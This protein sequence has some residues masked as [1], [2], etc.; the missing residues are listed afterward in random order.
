M[1]KY[2]L[3]VCVDSIESARNAVEAGADRLEICGNLANGGGTTPSLGLVKRIIAMFPEVPLMVMIRPRC[4]DF[5]YTDLELDV[6]REDIDQFKRIGAAG[7]VL[8]VL[9]VDGTVDIERTKRLTEAAEGLQGMFDPDH[10]QNSDT[11]YYSGGNHTVLL[12]LIQLADLLRAAPSHLAIMPGSGISAVTIREI[13]GY[14]VGHGLREV[15]M[16]GGQW[17]PGRSVWRKAGMGMGVSKEKEWDIWT[18]SYENVRAV[19]E[20]LDAM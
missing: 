13:S 3:E 11:N 4:G 6:M 2:I 9:T 17:K 16:S 8:G 7:V 5:V 19:R 1:S 20:A 15:H 18:T 14:L 12:S 10:D